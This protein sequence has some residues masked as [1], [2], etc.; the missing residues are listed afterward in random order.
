MD[1]TP[2]R[3]VADHL[4]IVMADRD[5]R[6]VLQRPAVFSSADTFVF[7][8]PSDPPTIAELE[9][10]THRRRRA[11][12][13]P[14]FHMYLYR[15][16]R[17]SMREFLSELLDRVSMQTPPIDLIQAIVVPLSTFVLGKLGGITPEEA[18]KIQRYH[19][20]LPVRPERT[21]WQLLRPVFLAAIARR[22]SQSSSHHQKDV[23][24]LLIETCNDKEILSSLLY[25]LRMNEATHVL[26]TNVIYELLRPP[27]RWDQVCL[28]PRL[29][30]FAI[31]EAARLHPPIPTLT[32]T[33][34]EDTVVGGV[35]IPAGACL[36]LLLSSANR[37][38]WWPHPE[39]FIFPRRERSHLSFG[40]GE[41][42]CLGAP[43][44][45]AEI[46]LV[47][48]LFCERFPGL[49][50]AAPVHDDQRPKDGMRHAPRPLLVHLK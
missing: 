45:R 39:S 35:T 1:A 40:Y 47:L 44:A 5:I 29:I 10:V 12:L 7:R 32:R 19:P 18:Q 27:R 48:E 9:G 22:R 34:T 42:V 3:H 30:G 33:C 28:F 20:A 41:H 50:L 38:E 2:V 21:S 46:S 17:P 37:D 4:F 11:S 8:R 6:D 16:L 15:S 14:L 25:L 24:S 43:L 31:E 23:I 13:E 49:R 26:L 36:A